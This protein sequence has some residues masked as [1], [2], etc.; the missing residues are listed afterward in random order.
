MN[1]CHNWL[2]YNLNTKSGCKRTGLVCIFSETWFHGSI[3]H[4]AYHYA[5][6]KSFNKLSILVQS[7]SLN[8]S[9]SFT[10]IFFNN[11]RK[12]CY[13]N[14]IITIISTWA[15]QAFTFPLLYLILSWCFSASLYTVSHS[16]LKGSSVRCG[17]VFHWPFCGCQF[18]M[19]I[20]IADNNPLI[21]LRKPI[22]IIKKQFL[23]FILNARM[24]VCKNS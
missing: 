24:S 23:I 19:V 8:W 20:Y 18:C 17:L 13:N 4:Y 1:S 14:E 10:F 2:E 12:E 6:N 11:S 15:T 5:Q 7:A 9:H 22:M 21:T 16:S 3:G